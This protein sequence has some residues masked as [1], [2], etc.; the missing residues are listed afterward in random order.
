MKTAFS[1]LKS[2]YYSSDFAS[3][4]YL[5]GEDFYA[6]IGYD[7]ATLIK[8]NAGYANTCAARMSLALLGASISFRGRLQVK[9]GNYKGR[10][11]ETGAKLL[12]DQLAKHSVFGYPEIFNTP[13][14]APAQIAGRRGMI[15]FNK[16][17]GYDGGHIDLIDASNTAAT[18]NSHCYFNCQ[19]VWFWEL[20]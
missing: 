11:I 18:C 14:E 20:S 7:R 5:S 17:S 10:M 8:Q 6:L 3:P 12:A 4:S 19:Q 1:I 15:F 9:A 16:I 2:K 13:A